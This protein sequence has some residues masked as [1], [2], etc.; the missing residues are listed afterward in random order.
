MIRLNPRLVHLRAFGTDGESELIK[1][2]H[3]CFP[4]AIHLRCT[5]HLRQNIKEKLCDL[6][7]AQNIWKEAYPTLFLEFR[8]V[9][10]LNVN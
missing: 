5:N 7:I 4:Q 2:F 9:L 3:N 10:I 8:L 6:K 1:A